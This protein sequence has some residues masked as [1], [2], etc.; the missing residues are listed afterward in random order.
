MAEVLYKIKDL[1]IISKT[2]NESRIILDK[3]N[4]NI[5]KHE[6]LGLVGETGS[7]KSM[8]GGALIGLLPSGC[9]IKSGEISHFFDSVIKKRHLRGSK[10]AMI[11]QDPMQSLNPLQTIGTQFSIILK[12]RFNCNQPD[13]KKRIFRWVQKVKLHKVPGILNRYPH[14]LSGGQMQ[15][16]MIAIAMSVEPEFI[17]ADEITTGLDMNTKMEIMTL[18]FSLQK[19]N[20]ISVLFISHDLIVVQKYCDRVV[21]L[22]SS[23]IIE[24]NDSKTIINKTDNYVNTFKKSQN[25]NLNKKNN[26][27]L[28]PILY[29]KE[30]YKNYGKNKDT[31]LGLNGISFEIYEGETLGV[32]GESG[33]G[34]TTLV[35]TVLNILERDS[36]NIYLQKQRLNKPNRKIGAIFQ[37][38]KGA[39]N[40]QMSIHDILCEPLVI[41]GVK[42]FKS[43]QKKTKEMLA[44]VNLDVDLLSKFPHQLSGGQRQ[45]VSI[46]R[47]LMVNPSVLILDEPTSSLDIYTQK[48]ILHLLQSLQNEYKMSYVFIS[49]D[50]RIVSKIA[51]RIIV[52]YKGS[53]VE[54]GK[55]TDVLCY[56]S[57]DYT[58]KLI[59]SNY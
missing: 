17:I 52:L 26:N 35:K 3:I 22:K 20:K 58:K 45:R 39:L 44:K 21:L 18:L 13:T 25:K 1:K 9:F 57:H 4:L 14:Q 10:V 42:D 59:D 11:S 29:V 7:G 55:T 27:T 43:T 37:D 5:H 54:H 2:E 38:N 31:V 33:S 40:P 19:N 46:A 15:R 49:H 24:L 12:K 36:G 51:D 6:I 48:K 23:E 47:A 34:K 53:I 28:G 56:P 16:I 50:L 30:L 8:I 32:I 41:K